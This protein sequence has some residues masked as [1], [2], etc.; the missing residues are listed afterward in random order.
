MGKEVIICCSN[1]VFRKDFG[2]EAKYRKPHFDIAQKQ[3]LIWSDYNDLTQK[4]TEW[5]KAIVG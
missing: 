2:A 5:I 4:L 1:E 3:L